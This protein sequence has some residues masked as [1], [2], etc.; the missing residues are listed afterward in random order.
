MGIVDYRSENWRLFIDSSYVSLKC[1]L[2]H[3]GNEYA[4]VPIGYSTKLKEEYDNIKTVLQKLVF[5]EHK[6]II[7]VDLKMVNYL[8]GQQSGYTFV[9]VGQQSTKSALEKSKMA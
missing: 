6:W 1:V 7:C 5:D 9:F 2:L 3:N 4:P 8:L